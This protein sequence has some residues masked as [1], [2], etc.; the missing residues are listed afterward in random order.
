MNFLATAAAAIMMLASATPSNPVIAKFLSE[1]EEQAAAAGVKNPISFEKTLFG[2]DA[3]IVTQE[4]PA[5]SADLQQVP[6]DMMKKQMVDEMKSDKES[7][8]LIQ[9]LKDTNTM[10]ILR[11]VGNDGGN[12]DIM[13]MPADFK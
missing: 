2:T 10:F 12:V 1:A 8:D 6:T 13:I 9:A 3:I 11:L 7:Q 5:S 4:V